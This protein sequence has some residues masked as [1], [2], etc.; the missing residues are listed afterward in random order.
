MMLDAF[1]RMMESASRQIAPRSSRR[2]VLARLGTAL[3]G[4]ALRKRWGGRPP[5]GLNVPRCGVEGTA[6]GVASMNEVS[7]IG[8]DLAKTVFQA[9]GAAAQRARLP[10]ARAV[11][12][13]ARRARTRCRSAPLAGA[14]SGA[15]PVPRRQRLTFVMD[16]SS[17]KPDPQSLPS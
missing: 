10:T 14:R 16:L 13:P 5:N 8:L 2:S 6:T 15:G 3:I 9:H 12:A 7:I 17:G 4:G 1:D 11:R